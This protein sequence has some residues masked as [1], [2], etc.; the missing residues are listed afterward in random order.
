MRL[1]AKRGFTLIELLVVVA[2]IALLI[3]ILIPSLSRR[4][5]RRRAV[6]AA[7]MKAIGSGTAIYAAENTD[8]VP[9]I[10][11]G[12][13]WWWDLPIGIPDAIINAKASS[14]N[15]NPQSMRRIWYC[16][17]NKGQ[18]EG[19]AN[20]TD[21]WDF[22][23]SYRVVGYT[24]FA[25]RPVGS[26]LPTPLNTSGLTDVPN[27][28][29]AGVA[30]SPPLKLKLKFGELVTGASASAQVLSNDAILSTTSSPSGVADWTHIQGGFAIAHTTSHMQG[31]KPAGGVQLYYDGHALWSA[32]KGTGGA[33]GVGTGGN[34][35][36]SPWFWVTQP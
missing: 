12:G 18:N 13:G 14:T 35:N 6:C 10:G 19:F 30:L 24:W 26:G 34:A 7:N 1:F 29:P 16:P 31:D 4:D 32:W 2:I 9:I 22:T 5:R 20:G 28:P 11:S 3:A 8:Y 33:A 23:S 21:L 25:A 36:S 27:P 15:L 17:S